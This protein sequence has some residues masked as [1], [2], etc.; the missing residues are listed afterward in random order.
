MLGSDLAL[1]APIMGEREA[2]ASSCGASLVARSSVALE[3][4]KVTRFWFHAVVLAS[5]VLWQ[6]GF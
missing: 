2:A 4:H 1:L 3:E 5:A 6:R